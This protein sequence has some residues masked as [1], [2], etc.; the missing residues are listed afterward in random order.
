MHEIIISYLR[1]GNRVWEKKKK[2]PEASL[3]TLHIGIHDTAYS[4]VRLKAGFAAGYTETSETEL[5][6]KKDFFPQKITHDKTFF[7]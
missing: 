2:L 4:A 7:F 1:L 5:W 6:I 3:L